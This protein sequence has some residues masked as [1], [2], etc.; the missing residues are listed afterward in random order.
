MAANELMA[1]NPFSPSTIVNERD[2][3]MTSAAHATV[4]IVDSPDLSEDAHASLLRVPS[5]P[6]TGSP[7]TARTSA[8]PR[9]PLPPSASLFRSTATPVS[10][11]WEADTDPV[12][13]VTMVPFDKTVQPY[14]VRLSK[15]AP[16]PAIQRFVTST[17]PDTASPLSETSSSSS[18]TSS[19]FVGVSPT[20][21]G[22]SAPKPL[23]QARFP[24]PP[25][26]PPGPL[27]PIPNITACVASRAVPSSC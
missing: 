16:V 18:S 8:Q 26:P 22:R 17:S 6:L 1:F 9:P 14:T 25:Y 20:K 21:E 11:A 24:P 27:S 19:A 15:E 12:V 13:K 3:P 5:V 4:R 23:L 7:A 10:A 2:I